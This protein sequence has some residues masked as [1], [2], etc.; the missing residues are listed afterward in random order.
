YPPRFLVGL[1]LCRGSGADSS[2]ASG[3][4]GGPRGAAALH[5]S[6][7]PEEPRMSAVTETQ[8]VTD[9]MRRIL[10]RQRAA[11]LADM[12]PP[13]AVR[14]DRLDRLL[15][16]TERHTDALVAAISEDFGHRSRQETLLTDVLTVIA[17]IKHARRHLKRWMKPRRAPTALQY[18]PAHNR[19][20]RQP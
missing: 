13:C 2:T 3:R 9:R 5:L 20:L 16:M 14:R 10:E 4:G 12:N 18:R 17:A 19:I 1:V 7:C 8:P 6:L 11:F 15:A